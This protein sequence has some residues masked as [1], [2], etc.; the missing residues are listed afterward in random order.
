MNPK[1]IN[2]WLENL[3][4]LK[5]LWKELHY[6]YGFKFLITR[7][8]TQDCIE[9]LFSIIRSKGGNNVTPD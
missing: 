5:L 3:Q 1:C 7:R 8:L 9:N 2:G 4:S 6:N